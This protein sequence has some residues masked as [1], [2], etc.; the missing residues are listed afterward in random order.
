MIWSD[1]S[2]TC[3]NEKIGCFSD[4]IHSDQVLPGIIFYTRPNTHSQDNDAQN[5]NDKIEQEERVADHVCCTRHFDASCCV[6]VVLE[7]EE[8]NLLGICF[9][10]LKLL[11]PD[12]FEVPAVNKNE[13]TFSIFVLIFSVLTLMNLKRRLTK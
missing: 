12:Y 6:L 7:R 10:S 3:S 8:N 1:I 13:F 9:F 4:G 11:E 5:P 2:R